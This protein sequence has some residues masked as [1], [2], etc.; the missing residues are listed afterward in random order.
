MNTEFI[1][2]YVGQIV[3]YTLIGLVVMGVWH[4]IYKAYKWAKENLGEPR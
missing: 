3:I 2:N 4:L 1:L